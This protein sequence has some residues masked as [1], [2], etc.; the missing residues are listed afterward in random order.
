M[1]GIL[2]EVLPCPRTRC[3][4]ARPAADSS[5][6]VCL[7][8]C[9]CACRPRRALLCFLRLPECANTTVKLAVSGLEQFIGSTSWRLIRF[10]GKVALLDLTQVI[11]PF[12]VA[13]GCI[14]IDVFAVRKSEDR[15]RPRSG[16]KGPAFHV[17]ESPQ[18]VKAQNLEKG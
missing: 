10:A 5:L 15:N 9:V 16:K 2:F 11:L 1:N 4:G 18:S 8:V 7:S 3:T 17:L 6:S 13:P 12:S 14:C